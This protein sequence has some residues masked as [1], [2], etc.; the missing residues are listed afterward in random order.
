MADT[1]KGQ[2]SQGMGS[3]GTQGTQQFTDPVCGMNVEQGKSAGT[4][5]YQGQTYNFCS[6]ECKEQFDRSPQQYAKRTA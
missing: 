4:S 1:Q 6:R 5:S 3:Q 2:G